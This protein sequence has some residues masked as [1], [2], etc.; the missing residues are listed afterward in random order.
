MPAD[1]LWAFSMACNVYLALF[2][3]YNTEM[4]RPLEWK[5]FLFCYG[6]PFIPALVLLFIDTREHGKAYGFAIVSSNTHQSPLTAHFSKLLY[7]AMVL[8]FAIIRLFANSCVLRTGL[9]RYFLNLFHL[10]SS[11]HLYLP[12][13]TTA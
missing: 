8:D 2:H 7:A 1:S 12:A 4:L 10:C 3:H 6:L 5:Y 13:A 11:R 9:V